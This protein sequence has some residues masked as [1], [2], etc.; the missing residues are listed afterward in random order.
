[1]N[2]NTIKDIASELFLALKKQE[3]IEPLTERYPEIDINDAY[4]ISRKFLSLREE[5]GEKIIGKKNWCNKSRC[6]RNAW[7]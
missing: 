1:M 2:L 3:M 6:S 5:E 4:Q 7:G